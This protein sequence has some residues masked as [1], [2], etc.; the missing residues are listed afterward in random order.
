[1]QKEQGI[2]PGPEKSKGRALSEETKELVINFYQD[3]E[4]SRILPGKKDSVSLG[5]NVH[6][7]KHLVLCNLKELFSAFKTGYPS[8]QI[9]F[10]SFCSLRPKWCVL[11]GASGTHAV[12]V[13]TIHQNTKLLINALNS[14]ED[15]KDMMKLLVCSTENRDCMIRQCSECPSSDI[16][17][18][19]LFNIIGEYDDTEITYKQWIT[20]DRSTL[21][22]MTTPVQ[23]FVSVLIDNLEKLTSHSYIAKSQSSYLQQLKDN[24]SANTAILLLDFVE[25]FAFT[26]QDEIH[27]YHWNTSQATLHPVCVYHRVNDH[28][29]CHS[30][31]IISDDMD[32]DVSLVHQIQKEWIEHAKKKIQGL[33]KIVYFSD[34]CAA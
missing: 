22:Q 8:T 14:K 17:K 18:D 27:S 32:H 4:F 24:I 19:H 11:A 9:G 23:E 20:T 7:Q 6:K 5:R 3:E 29:R 34:G 16:L 2:L 15:Y 30:F 26:I 10:S 31:C 12:C 25:N 1:M 13:C 28:P 33:T 21:A